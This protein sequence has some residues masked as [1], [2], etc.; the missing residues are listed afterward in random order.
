MARPSSTLC[1]SCGQLVGVK[2]EQCLNCGRRNP[3]MWGFAHLLRGARDDAA[4]AQLVM[5]VCGALYLASLAVDLE[6]IRS[7]GML[8]FLQP[9]D[10]SLRLFGASG[11]SPV[12]GYHQW[13]TVLSASWLHGGVLHILFNMYWVRNLAVP[14]A[15]FYGAGRAVVIYV[16]S[17]VTGFVAS[18]LAFFLPLPIF[19]RGGYL[20]IGASASILGLLGA[21]LYYGRR[22]GSSQATQQA[23]SLALFLLILGFIMPGVDNWAHL[24]GLGGGYLVARWLDPLEPERGNHLL[25]ALGCLIASLL[26]ILASVVEGLKILR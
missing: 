3:G 11:A 5:W 21:L 15:H 17:G 16:L 20:S 10:R 25:I 9:S 24:G 14:T 19:L 6:G 26:A 2:D 1:P 12:F 13:W 7:G 23:K 8:S 18:S 4:F 22:S